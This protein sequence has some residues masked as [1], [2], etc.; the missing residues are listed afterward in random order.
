[1]NSIDDQLLSSSSTPLYTYADES[2]NVSEIDHINDYI[3]NNQYIDHNNTNKPT[4]Y[5]TDLLDSLTRSA[6]PDQ[7]VHQFNHT[8]PDLNTINDNELLLL[9]TSTAQQSISRHLLLGAACTQCYN[10]KVKCSGDRPCTRCKLA[11]KTCT[12]RVCKRK[13]PYQ[14]S[15]SQSNNVYD[16]DHDDTNSVK[17]NNTT[18]AMSK[19]SHQQSS[20]DSYTSNQ[21]DNHCIQSLVTPNQHYNINYNIRLDTANNERELVGEIVLDCL[22]QHL[23]YLSIRLVDDDGGSLKLNLILTNASHSLQPK[24]YDRLIDACFKHIQINLHDNT[25]Y[26]THPY[27]DID[28]TIHRRFITDYTPSPMNARICDSTTL[29]PELA[30]IVFENLYLTSIKYSNN[31]PTSTTKNNKSYTTIQ[32]DHTHSSR[33]CWTSTSNNRTS[34][35]IE[36]SLP[37]NIVDCMRCLS[38]SDVVQLQQSA[39]VNQSFERLFGYSQYEIRY[40]LNTIGGYTFWRLFNYQQ[41]ATQHANNISI[42]KQIQNIFN[43][44]HNA[45]IYGH[46]HY[47]TSTTIV[48]KSNQLIP[49][50]LQCRIIPSSDNAMINAVSY[51]F[52]PIPQ[53]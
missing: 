51:A 8:A 29:E 25:N 6:E 3:D 20:T 26:V 45:I 1:M 35:N 16:N 18:T 7:S 2:F 30:T 17:I 37:L 4:S 39:S 44:Q 15:P 52:I 31:H 36:L 19:L 5:R 10:S 28:H 53:S 32:Y 34:N 14:H 27:T 9:S 42:V 21:S 33:T 12:S 24:Q 43:L 41:Q 38:D 46:L 48:T 13:Q 22:L 11:N 47:S 50:I 23:H 49:C 40:M